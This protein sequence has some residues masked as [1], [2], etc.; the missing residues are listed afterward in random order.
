MKTAICL[1][2][3]YVQGNGVLSETGHYVGIVGR[4]PLLLWGTHTREA[5]RETVL[6]SLQKEGLEAAE[7]RFG[8]EC[9]REEARRVAGF[10]AERK[11]DV[12][13][14]LGGGKAIDAAKGA[15]A[16]AGLPAV[17]IP[18]IASNDAPTSACTV[19]YNAKGTCVGYNVWKFNPDVVLVDTGVVAKAPERFFVAGMGDAL[20]TWPE[21]N[22]AYQTRT[23]SAAGG[24]AT[25]TALAMARLC[26]DTI[27]EFGLEA[28]D[29]V[30]KGEVTP[31]LERVVEAN[32]LLS[33]VGWESGGLACAHAMANALP[34]LPETHDRLHGEKVAFGLVTQLCL[35][36]D[37]REDEVLR[38]VDHMV[39]L[40]LPVTLAGLGLAD[41]S[42]Q[43]LQDFAQAVT[44]KGSFVH[45]HNFPVTAA[46]LADAILAADALG[47]SRVC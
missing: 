24:V 1:P 27:M 5:V 25:Q 10:A 40:G 16:L 7:V 15:A 30:R 46:S 12:V 41:L 2:R 8:G 45:N 21:A 17:M 34:A 42:S 38:I 31:A 36:K 32:V 20:A 47:R 28:R 43:R 44:A 14:G 37:R 11:T 29:A 4:R 18:T 3:K 33:G 13:V 19:W 26:F 39:A 23:V 35:E 6:P 22:A 9:T